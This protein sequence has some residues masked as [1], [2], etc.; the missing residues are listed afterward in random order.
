M[1]GVLRIIPLVLGWEELPKSFSVY[2]ADPGIRMREPVPGILLQL[3]GGWML[4]D[5]GF[6]P[7]LIR[8]PL[9]YQRFHGGNHNIAAFLPPGDGDP[10]ED[11]VEQVGLALEDVTVVALSHLH[12][13][14]A[15]GVRHFAR[16]DV[17]VHVQQRELDY[18]LGAPHPDQERH[19]MFRIDYDD[20]AISWAIAD[21]DSEIAPGVTAILTA[22]HTPG[23]QS[24]VVD[25]DPS[26]GGGGFVFAF[27]AA[28]LQ[29]NIDDEKPVGGT[30]G[31][32]PEE[33]LEPLL[34]LKAIAREKGYRMVPG[35]DPHAWPLLIKELT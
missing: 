9:L 2:G 15:G 33:T 21:G 31:V 34:R 25:L 4:L 18:G 30:I 3:D 10:L 17:A 6:N 19:G 24:F 11:A 29:E 5:T 1:S 22:G 28:D 8:D 7:S 14:H 26:V 32:H 23:H 13:D 16:R 12:N 35:H 20:P 27:D